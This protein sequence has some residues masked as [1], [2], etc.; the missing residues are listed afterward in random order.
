MAKDKKKEKRGFLNR[1]RF[2]SVVTGL[3]TIIGLLGFTLFKTIPL[4]KIT[5]W[6]MFKGDGPMV[7]IPKGK[8][9]MGSNFI[10]SEQPIH[11]VYV[12][13]FYM[14]K[15]EVTNAEYKR[16]INANSEWQKDRISDV[17]HDGNYLNHWTGN[18]YP[19][20]RGNYPVT[21][22]SWY[23]AMAYTRWIDKRLPTEA[24]W[25]KAAWGGGKRGALIVGDSSFDNRITAVGSY[26]PNPYGLYDMRRN[27]WEWCLD[28]YDPDFYANSP[29]SNPFSGGF[30][31][32]VVNIPDISEK[33][34]VVR[35]G[36]GLR[37][38]RRNT[39]RGRNVPT[40][41]DP[42]SGFRCVKPAKP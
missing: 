21:N 12:D 42:Y 26:T 25:E 23:A 7:R 1:K 6:D 20:D 38:S 4:F 17:Y 16:F 28:E 13:A 33:D 34:R 30:I 5:L 10:S 27:V 18:D 3:L 2:L 31:T 32:D 35:G 11:T 22:V 37:W 19:K 14:D 8:F 15:Y 24:E 41:T 39:A 36:L 40:A 9:Q 29:S